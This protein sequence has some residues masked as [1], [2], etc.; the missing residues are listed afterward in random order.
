MLQIQQ[1]FQQHRKP[2]RVQQHRCVIAQQRTEARKPA[3]TAFRNT[4]TAILAAGAVL[5]PHPSL[6]VSGGGGTCEQIIPG[7]KISLCIT[8]VLTEFQ[9]ATGLG[10]PHNYEDLSHKDLKKNA[11]TKAEL[12]QTNFSYSDLSGVSLFGALAKGANFE[13]ATLRA[14]DLESC[15]L[16]DANFTNAVLEGAMVSVA[17]T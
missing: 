8:L 3:E 9:Y 5:L 14:T 12:R 11:Y 6:A 13:G 1:A 7:L 15:D 4:L 2:A 10:T 17:A 16:E